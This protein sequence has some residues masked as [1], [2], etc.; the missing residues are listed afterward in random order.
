MKVV[1]VILADFVLADTILFISESA[2]LVANL[3][4]IVIAYFESIV[5]C[6]SILCEM[7]SNI[8][9]GSGFVENNH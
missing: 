4:R 8:V 5:A 7:F 1:E 2:K 6:M 3:S 9:F